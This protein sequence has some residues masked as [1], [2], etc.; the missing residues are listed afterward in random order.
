ME[1]RARNASSLNGDELLDE[2]EK[3]LVQPE[4]G[5]GCTS[6]EQ[7]NV[8]A[9]IEESFAS[10]KREIEARVSWRIHLSSDLI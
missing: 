10:V 4:V 3:T 6:S 8:L 2:L 1:Q 5:G 7:V 9:R